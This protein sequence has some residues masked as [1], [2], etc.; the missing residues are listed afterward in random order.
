MPNRQY[1]CTGYIAGISC[2]VGTAVASN[3]FNSGNAAAALVSDNVAA[4]V[5]R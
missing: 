4:G 3:V 5:I 1:I 2:P